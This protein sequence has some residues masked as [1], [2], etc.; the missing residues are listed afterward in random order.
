MSEK[1]IKKFKIISVFLMFFPLIGF[2]EEKIEDRLS[3]INEIYPGFSVLWD[4]V[5]T[6][7]RDSGNMK[8][9]EVWFNLVGIN[10]YSSEKEMETD[11]PGIKSYV[12]TKLK[13]DNQ[14]KQQL[15]DLYLWLQRQDEK[16]AASE[17][18]VYLDEETGKGNFVNFKPGFLWTELL[19][20]GHQSPREALQI[21]AATLADPKGSLDLSMPM[22]YFLTD[23]QK[24]SLEKLKEDLMKMPSGG[25]D[26][27]EIR[28]KMNK[29]YDQMNFKMSK[30]NKN[31]HV[32]FSKNKILI[33]PK[34]LGAN[35]DISDDLKQKIRTNINAGTLYAKFYHV[36]LAAFMSCEMLT[37]GM[38]PNLT[39][40]MQKWTAWA[41]RTLKLNLYLKKLFRRESEH[42]DL[43]ESE[44]VDLLASKLMESWFTGE[45]IGSQITRPYTNFN[46]SDLVFTEK[47]KKIPDVNEN[48]S[49]KTSLKGFP[50]P[51]FMEEA[52][53][54]L[55]KKRLRLWLTEWEWT[56]AQ[57]EIGSQL[58]I[59]NCRDPK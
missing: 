42:R 53:F 10:K 14:F 33:L 31:A 56:I 34:N 37:A 51:L 39:L 22:E 38:N 23:S 52:E 40:M 46:L 16:Y 29:I 35:A 45:K 30:R 6:L 20:L 36:Q 27:M 48:S 4:H 54:K 49:F 5:K 41:Y 18:D 21:L 55:A 26:F 12:E 9:L 28:E 19:R 32:Q 1:M 58:A 59:A 8:G 57:H 24:T 17:E 44:K 3:E 2:A 43:N 15:Y 7:P 50:K 13:E 25:K 47:Y 11:L